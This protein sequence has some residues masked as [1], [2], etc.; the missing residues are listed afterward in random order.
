M[1]FQKPQESELQEPSLSPP[2]LKTFFL[3]FFRKIEE[4]VTLTIQILSILPLELT[5]HHRGLFLPT[6]TFCTW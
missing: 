6:L 2:F 4:S 5:S 3:S 1:A